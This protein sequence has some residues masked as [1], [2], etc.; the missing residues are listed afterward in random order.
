MEAALN[1]VNDRKL[2]LGLENVCTMDAALNPTNRRKLKLGLENVCKVE[3]AL[4]PTNKNKL[5][6]GL[7]NI[8]TVEAAHNHTHENRLKMKQDDFQKGRT[9]ERVARNP[10]VVAGTYNTHDSMSRGSNQNL[11]A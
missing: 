5:K 11:H 1:P 7:K 4:N 6:F 2:K 8:C 10:L 9:L 3:E